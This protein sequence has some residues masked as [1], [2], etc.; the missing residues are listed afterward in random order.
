MRTKLG[1]SEWVLV[2][3]RGRFRSLILAGRMLTI[4]ILAQ[5][6]T[7]LASAPKS[8]AAYLAVDEATRDVEEVARFATCPYG[9]KCDPSRTSVNLYGDMV[10]VGR[11]QGENSPVW[12]GDG[13]STVTKFA[14]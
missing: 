8:N 13:A 10:V 12:W 5:A 9:D 14:A 4:A 1:I 7:Y 2:R 11:R 6:T 3:N